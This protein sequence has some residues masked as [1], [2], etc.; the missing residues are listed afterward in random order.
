MSGWTV[1]GYN[2]QIGDSEHSEH[3]PMTIGDIMNQMEKCIYI[4]TYN[5]NTYI[6]NQ[7][8]YSIYNHIQIKSYTYIFIYI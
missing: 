6:Y 3:I 5:D 7:K 8:I 2:Q 1:G 4:Y